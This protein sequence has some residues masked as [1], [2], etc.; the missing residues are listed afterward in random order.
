MLLPLVVLHVRHAHLGLYIIV[1]LKVRI[2]HI[3]SFGCG[4]TYATTM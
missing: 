3:W 1:S 4:F 2:T